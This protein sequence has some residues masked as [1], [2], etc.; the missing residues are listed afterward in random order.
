MMLY[1]FF[2]GLNGLGKMNG[3]QMGILDI[4]QVL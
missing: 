4:L 3:K 1:V 2:L